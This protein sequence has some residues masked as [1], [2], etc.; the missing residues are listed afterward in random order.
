MVAQSAKG[1]VRMRTQVWSLDLIFKKYP[2]WQYV[3]VI[4]AR[5]GRDKGSP[6][7]FWPANI[8]YM[9]SFRPVRDVISK[10]K[11]AGAWRW[12]LKVV[13]W[14]FFFYHN[15]THT[16]THIQEHTCVHTH[17][18]MCT[19]TWGWGSEGHGSMVEYLV[20]CIRAIKQS[21]SSSILYP[22]KEEVSTGQPR[23]HSDASGLLLQSLH[24]EVGC[25][26]GFPMCVM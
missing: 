8:A 2:A 11:V 5:G 26:H 24:G 20:A 4:R 21:S 7:V 14:L 12:T 16:Y 6:G 25:M 18:Y 10:T 17:T 9:P 22:Q 23:V 1:S 13:L 15:Y 19:Y 3:L